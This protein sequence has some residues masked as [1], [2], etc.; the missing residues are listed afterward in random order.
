MTIKNRKNGS[1]NDYWIIS[2]KA[3]DLLAASHQYLTN[4]QS[5]YR[6]FSSK[7]IHPTQKFTLMTLL[8]MPCMITWA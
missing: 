7:T 6:Q 4:V 5:C 8:Q 1:L 2:L 3:I